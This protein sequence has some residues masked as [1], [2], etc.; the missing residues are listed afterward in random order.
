MVNWCKHICACV[1]NEINTMS[2][3]LTNY[4]RIDKSSC[5]KFSFVSLLII[6]LKI[7]HKVLRCV[8]HTVTSWCWTRRLSAHRKRINGRLPQI[9]SDYPIAIRHP[10]SY[11]SVKTIQ[12]QVV[13]YL[14]RCIMI[15]SIYDY[16]LCRSAPNMVGPYF[17]IIFFLYRPKCIVF[18]RSRNQ[19]PG[20]FYRHYRWMYPT[21]FIYNRREQLTVSIWDT[22]SFY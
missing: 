5:T 19:E 12:D 3:L 21:L 18:R 15:K 7:T 9:I 8:V 4:L 11:G 16:M 10:S 14:H 13:G 20:V 22:M 1:W 17:A 6:W 2:I